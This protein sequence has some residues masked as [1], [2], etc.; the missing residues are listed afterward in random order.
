VESPEVKLKPEAK[1]QGPVSHSPRIKELQQ[2]DADSIFGG[3]WAPNSDV[4][5][6]FSS[7]N[8]PFG[9]APVAQGIGNGS[10]G[11]PAFSDANQQGGGGYYNQQPQDETHP[12]AFTQAAP[13]LSH[14]HSGGSA[15]AYYQDSGQANSQYPYQEGGYDQY[16]YPSYG[17]SSAYQQP[18]GDS[19]P[20]QPPASYDESAY[21]QHQRDRYGESWS[22]QQPAEQAFQ[23][24]QGGYHTRQASTESVPSGFSRQNTGDSYPGQDSRKLTPESYPAYGGFDQQTTGGYIGYMSS[25]PASNL[26]TQQPVAATGTFDKKSPVHNDSQASSPPLTYFQQPT[27]NSTAQYFTGYSPPKQKPSTGFGTSATAVGGE[28][29][30]KPTQSVQRLPNNQR[31]PVPVVAFGFGGLVVTMFPTKTHTFS[32]MGGG[33]QYGRSGS[34]MGSLNK[35]PV[36]IRSLSKVAKVVPD[37]D[38]WLGPITDVEKANKFIAAKSVITLKDDRRLLLNVVKV[39]AEHQGKLRSNKGKG[40]GCCH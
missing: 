15:D 7:G 38:T 36:Q 4:A 9:Q 19:S 29:T 25:P 10:D 24:D 30:A 12:D 40:N 32:Y 8:D 37:I 33:P 22:Y 20:Y 3:E 17:E 11:A 21:Q 5:Q 23:V 13:E 18:Y 31:P 6:F 16:Q 27:A 34:D 26:Q 28:W 14:Q 1:W 2:G 39:A 35:G